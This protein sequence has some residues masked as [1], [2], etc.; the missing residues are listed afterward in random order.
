MLR[1]LRFTS[2]RALGPQ[3]G[4]KA[5]EAAQAAAKAAE[6]VAGVKSCTMYLGNGA[7]IFAAESDGF[8]AAVAALADSGVQAAFG[9][10]GQEYGFG[11]SG[12]EF[13]LDPKQIYPF[14]QR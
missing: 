8:A 4:M 9:R 12:D 10:L 14:I 5:I 3:E 13:F 11:V 7:F 1:I 6:K 2:N